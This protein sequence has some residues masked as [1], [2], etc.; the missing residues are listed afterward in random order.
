[1]ECAVNEEAP[2]TTVPVVDV[3]PTLLAGLATD[4]GFGVRVAGTDDSA[5][6]FDEAGR[7]SLSS[8]SSS[9]MP[10]RRRSM[11]SI[12]L[13]L[14]QDK[15]RSHRLRAGVFYE[16]P[17]YSWVSKIRVRFSFGLLPECVHSIFASRQ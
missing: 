12:F 16:S 14:E 15:Q 17:Y 6:G 5:G 3:W 11:W 9:T 13:S 1:M 2:S 8:S 10:S 4:D 7:R